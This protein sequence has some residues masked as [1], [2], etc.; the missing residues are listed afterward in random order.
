MSPHEFLA[1]CAG[2]ISGAAA[3]ALLYLLARRRLGPRAETGL[4][5]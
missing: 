1:F 5:R 4:S 3:F 2:A